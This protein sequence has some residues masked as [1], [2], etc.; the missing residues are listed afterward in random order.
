MRAM[1]ESKRTTEA[2]LLTSINS[3]FRYNLHTNQVERQ[4][5]VVNVVIVTAVVCMY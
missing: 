5:K 4:A 1:R 3:C 2:N